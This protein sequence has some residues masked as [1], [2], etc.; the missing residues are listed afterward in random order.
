MHAQASSGE[1]DRIDR[2]TL[3][4]VADAVDAGNPGWQHLS[5]RS[6]LNRDNDGK[7]KFAHRSVMEFFF[8]VAAIDGDDR[9]FALPWTDVMRELLVSWGYTADGARRLNA[10]KRILDR[11]LSLT[12]L[13]PL[14]DPPV[15][16]GP[17]TLDDLVNSASRRGRRTGAR[18]RVSSRWRRDSVRL[19]ETPRGLLIDDIACDLEWQTP[20]MA[21][22]WETR[23][24]FLMPLAQRLKGKHSLTDLRA[25]SFDELVSLVEGLAAHDSLD[26]LGLNRL[27]LLGDTLN[28]QHHLLAEVHVDQP[29]NG[30]LHA[31]HA[32]LPVVGTQARV[33]VYDVGR[34]RDPA[35]LQSTNVSNLMVRR[36]TLV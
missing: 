25:P 35:Q 11:D 9:C 22:D 29:S 12:G 2:A 21:A 16:P 14:T 36:R 8:V 24:A 1:G 27:H 18:R 28:P 19:V 4:R 23:D 10:A 15:L 20:Y 13:I 17:V 3:Q 31:V 34:Y 6:L 30:H 7:L 5:T 26:G 32:P 33:T